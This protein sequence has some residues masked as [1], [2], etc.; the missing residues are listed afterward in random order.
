MATGWANSALA[1]WIDATLSTHPMNLDPRQFAS[2]PLL[3][4]ETTSESSVDYSVRCAG[5]LVGRI[6]RS[7]LSGG[8]ESW[9][10]T[11]T[12]P[13]L[14]E[15]LRPSDGREGDLGGAKAA[16]RAKFDAWLQWAL[17]QDGPVPW[18]GSQTTQ[19]RR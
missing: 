6:L 10:W 15:E 17:E 4:I 5:Y 9:L 8:T 1:R 12:G 3:L 13:Y 7:D 18:H 2:K 11:V 19:Y 14:P 16:F